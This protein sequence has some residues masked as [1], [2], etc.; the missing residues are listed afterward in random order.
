M[1]VQNKPFISGRR[2]GKKIEGRKRS[3]L[4]NMQNESDKYEMLRIY[5]PQVTI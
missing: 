1:I 3:I 2:V 5:N 4:V